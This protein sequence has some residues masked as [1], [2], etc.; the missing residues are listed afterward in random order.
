MTDRPTHPRP[1]RFDRP[2]ESLATI[3]RATNPKIV[4]LEENG[5]A[6][7]R[8]RSQHRRY[9]WLFEDLMN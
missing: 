9:V 2:S 1:T 4:A 8:D 7:G 5:V 3:D 6:R